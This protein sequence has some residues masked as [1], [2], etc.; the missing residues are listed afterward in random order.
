MSEGLWGRV[1]TTVC[2][3][4]QAE[5]VRLG[6]NREGMPARIPGNA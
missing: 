1:Y 6:T 5:S 3:L 2:L 4:E